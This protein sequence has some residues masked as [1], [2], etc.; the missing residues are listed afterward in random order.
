MT[1]FNNA[2][3]AAKNFSEYVAT[4]TVDA[5]DKL[6]QRFGDAKKQIDSTR[7]SAEDAM[8]V[9]EGKKAEELQNKIYQIHTETLQKI[10]DDMS[11]K[12][13]AVV[14]AE[15]KLAIAE[16]RAATWHETQ[17]AKREVLAQEVQASY[18]RVAAAQEASAAA[19]DKVNALHESLA[20]VLQQKH[21][22]ELQAED[23]L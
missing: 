18:A 20:G 14:L 11:E 13:K 23:I 5:I 1:Y 22:L 2:R 16:Q 10:T 9:L 12:G 6:A 7:K 8:K 17:M 3:E 21:L 15:E 19:Q 4:S